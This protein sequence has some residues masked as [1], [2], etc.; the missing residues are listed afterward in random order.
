MHHILGW[1]GA[2]LFAI[3]AFPQ[4]VKTY[5][6]KRADDLS[7]L[8][9][10]FWGLGEIFTFIYIVIDDYIE[11]IQHWPLYLNYF[12]NI[13]MVAYLVYAKKVYHQ[14]PSR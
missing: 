14:A 5:K 11:H 6:T 8:F 13:L 10:L 3:C 12:F 7:W 2:I 9:L 4:V 1:L